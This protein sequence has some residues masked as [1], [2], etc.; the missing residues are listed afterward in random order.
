MRVIS[1]YKGQQVNVLRAKGE[2]IKGIARRLNLSKN[3]VRKYLRSSGATWLLG[4]P[5][6]QQDTIAVSKCIFVTCFM[7]ISVY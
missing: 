6:Q 3:T 2:S 7:P 5:L 4:R 1:I